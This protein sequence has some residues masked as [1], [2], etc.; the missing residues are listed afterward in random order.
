MFNT[1]KL[2]MWVQAKL[3]QFLHDEKGEVN[4]VSIVVLI[5]IA[6]VLAIVFKDAISN[7]LKSLLNTIDGTAQNAVAGI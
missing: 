4:I 7:L 5:G 1:M 6:V 2:Q 3:N